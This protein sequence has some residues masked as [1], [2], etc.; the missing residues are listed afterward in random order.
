MNW[1]VAY[2]LWAVC[3]VTPVLGCCDQQQ[4]AQKESGT[5]RAGAIRCIQCSEQLSDCQLREG[6]WLVIDVLKYIHKTQLF[7][8]IDIQTC[9]VGYCDF[10][11]T[12]QHLD[13]LCPCVAVPSSL[14]TCLLLPSDECCRPDQPHIVATSTSKCAQSMDMLVYCVL[15]CVC[16]FTVAGGAGD[17]S[18]LTCV[19]LC[20]RV[21]KSNHLED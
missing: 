4:A 11:C 19:Y 20:V 17:V 5:A 15:L 6:C 3:L 2:G 1:Q 7:K 9:T 21:L 14:H 16:V 10:G 8:S 13:I 18:V 12:V